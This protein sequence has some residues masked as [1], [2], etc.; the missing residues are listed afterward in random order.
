ML[1]TNI[2]N[3]YN[4]T[5]P[6][7]YWDNFFT[8]EELTKIE[9]YLDS[10]IREESNV[11]DEKG[12]SLL[13]PHVR[14]SSVALIGFAE[15]NQWIFNRL[16]QLTEFINGNFYN[17]DL[18]GFNSIQ[19]T[20]Y[21][22]PGDHYCYHMDMLLDNSPTIEVPRKLSFSIVFSDEAVDFMGGELQFKLAE[23]FELT[24]T[25]KRGRIFA[26][27]SYILHKVA[28]ITHGVRKSLV[29]WACGPKFK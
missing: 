15:D 4:T 18:L 19:Y 24:S 5:V 3:T 1:S 29:F 21:D 25:Q 13:D 6:Y 28:P 11:Y 12:N 17:Y 14:N 8:E 2:L 26:F 27:P 22:K 9:Y 23:D 20:V 16:F 7:I 10:Q